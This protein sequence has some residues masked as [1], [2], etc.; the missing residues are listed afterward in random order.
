MDNQPV[1]DRV[2]LSNYG[3]LYDF[4]Q[5]NR[6]DPMMLEEFEGTLQEY[7]TPHQAKNRVLDLYVNGAPE[8]VGELIYAPDSEL[9]SVG[10]GWLALTIEKLNTDDGEI[11]SGA[12]FS[13]FIEERYRKQGF[14]TELVLKLMEDFQ[15]MQGKSEAWADRKLWTGARDE[16]I[17]SVRLLGS[18]GFKKVGI[19]ARAPE[20]DVYT[21]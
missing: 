6:E 16:N 12:N 18:L 8:R 11:F 4:L 2:G 19:L 17:A 21:Y 20:Y 10:F 13:T 1:F 14:G 3:V 15:V 9:R 7:I 5:R